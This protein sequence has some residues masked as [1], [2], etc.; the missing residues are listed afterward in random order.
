M[1]HLYFNKVIKMVGYVYPEQLTNDIYGSVI[2]NLK[3]KYENTVYRKEGY[4]VKIY[5]ITDHE[6]FKISNS[7]FRGVV[8][9]ECSV[10]CYMFLPIVG[11]KILCK[12]SHVSDGI[13]TGNMGSMIIIIQTNNIDRKK[14]EVGSIQLIKLLSIKLFTNH[15]DICS[16]GEIVRESTDKEKKQFYIESHSNDNQEEF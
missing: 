4:I 1:S 7:D 13:I 8:E 6:N 12:I 2:T 11:E 15:T 3:K 16:E 14:I 9:I 5:K 10:L